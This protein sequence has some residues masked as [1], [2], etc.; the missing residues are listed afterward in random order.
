M[1][2]REF[3]AGA[4]ATS[5]IG[6]ARAQQK[7]KVY[8]LAVVASAGRVPRLS[9]TEHPNWRAFL[10]E[11]RRL[12]YVEEQNL[13][14]ERYS[15]EGHPERYHDLIGEVVRSN[16]DA[17]YIYTFSLAREF[18]VQ[19]TTIPI[20]AVALDPVGTGLV[21]SVARPGGNITGVFVANE[22]WGKRLGLLKEAIPRLS[23]V[24]LLLAP[25]LTAQYGTAMLKEASEKLNISLVGP[26]IDSP[27]DET[28]YRRAFALMVQ[29]GAEAVY[30]GDQLES[31]IN[32]P[33]IIELAQKNRLP[34]IYPMP[35]AIEA[36]GFMAYAIDYADL[37]QHAA[38]T[39]D[40]IFKG[41][42]PGDIPFYQAVKVDFLI[43][44]K[45]A[46]ALGLEISPNLLAQADE[47]IE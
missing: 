44:I 3:I 12:G 31:W 42:K 1:R 14:V 16:P 13:T 2:R 27:F 18:K 34:T 21:P 10:G 36:G 46:K 45:T 39:I 43:N 37:W 26:P 28:A 24:G 4:V 40:Q 25:T 17:V 33:V 15:A 32:L 11:L 6:R 22:I 23:R 20:V 7:T 35:E 30:V 29:E 38:D 5:A 47:V 8:R 9:E 41:T 19:T